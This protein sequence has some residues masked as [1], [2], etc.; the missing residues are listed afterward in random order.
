MNGGAGAVAGGGD[1]ATIRAV[2]ILDSLV[3]RLPDGAVVTGGQPVQERAID[4]WPLALL[5]Q[6]RGDG[7]PEP[8]AVVFPFATEDVAAVLAWASNTGTAVIPRGGGSGVCGGAEAGA[9]SVVLDLSRM[10]KVTDVDVVS[11]VVHVQAGVRGDRLEDALAGHGLTVGHYPQSIAISTVGGWIAACSA[12]QASTGFGAIEDVLLGLTAVL[13]DGEILRC[14]PV[15]RSAAGPDLRRLLVGSEGTLAVVTEAALACRAR[16][17]GWEWLVREFESFAALADG[18]REAVRAE[19]GAAVLRGYDETDAAFSFGGLG[20]SGGCVAM[21]GFPAGLAALEERRRLA[22]G[23]LH[24]AGASGE[25]ASRYGEHWW[26]HRND[27]VGTFRQIMG[28]ER[29]FGTGV[30]VDTIEVAGLWSAVPALYAGVRAALAEHAEA[31][32]CHLSHLYSSGSSLYFTFL[33]RGTDDHDVQARY[34]AAWDQA[35][36]SCAANG[37]TIT[38]HHGVGR[39]KSAFLPTELGESGVGV[40]RRIKGAVDPR[41]IMNPGVLLP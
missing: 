8:A 31:V 9:G 11:R 5:R 21:L 38:H 16:P 33:I 3:R 39:L 12:G 19:T 2:D 36:R 28:P 4:C 41:G 25:L 22:A 35:V 40:L 10:D 17:A 23:V 20:H 32:G 26:E 27:T 15:P 18:L 14:R 1:W 6:V 24:Q 13:P 34:L 7:L 29:A 37:G 30:V